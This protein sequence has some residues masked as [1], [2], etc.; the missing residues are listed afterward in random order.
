MN[1]FIKSGKQP[2]FISIIALGLFIQLSGLFWVTNGYSTKVYLLLSLPTLL[3]AV[4][5][6]RY[7]YDNFLLKNPIGW[8]LALFFTLFS[9]SGLWSEAGSYLGTASKKSLLCLLYVISVA[10]LVQKSKHFITILS[11][12]V[13]IAGIAALLTLVNN[14]LIEGIPLST[15]IMQSNIGELA[16]FKNPIIAG[17]V[18]CN[19][20]LC[21]IYL[22]T[23]DLNKHIKSAIIISILL[24]IITALFTQSRTSFLGVILA[25]SGLILVYPRSNIKWWGV[26]MSCLLIIIMMTPLWESFITRSGTSWRPQIWLGAVTHLLKEAPFLGFGAGSEE[27][28]LATKLLNGTVTTLSWG[29]PHNGFILASM[30]TGLLGFLI[31]ASLFFSSLKSLVVR[32]HSKL[33]PLA[34]S[35]TLFSIGV[36]ITDIH[37]IVSRPGVY[38]LVIW[39]PI[40]IALGLFKQT[41]PQ[42][43]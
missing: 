27:H 35:L 14:F 9:L 2:I 3:Y 8:A 38:W 42:E 34:L 20:A 25:F 11:A 7:I 40:G 12:T 19:I 39:F 13:I 1:S 24:C 37:T 32:K 43:G 15:R 41:N 29:H 22:L 17:I 30:Q 36:Q 26:G 28:F 6:S 10:V 18:Y 33:A 16:D 23:T 31:Y 21:G 4:I 5:N